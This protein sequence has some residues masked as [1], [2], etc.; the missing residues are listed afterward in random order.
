VNPEASSK[1]QPIVVGSK[2][3]SNSEQVIPF[4]GNY[5]KNSKL[6]FFSDLD[7][8]EFVRLGQGILPMPFKR[9]SLGG[10]LASFIYLKQPNMVQ[11]NASTST[12]R[13][14]I[15]KK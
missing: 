2:S 9:S 13:L 8:L 12:W 15:R 10:L 3:F 11:K 7:H 6:I 1:L 5:G 4:L 14:L